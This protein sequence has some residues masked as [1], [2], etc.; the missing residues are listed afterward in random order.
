MKEKL[1]RGIL[2]V[3]SEDRKIESEKNRNVIA[4]IVH[5]M[6]ALNFYK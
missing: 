3:I 4:R 6:S 1:C 2:L 5:A